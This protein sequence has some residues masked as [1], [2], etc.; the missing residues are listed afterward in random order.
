MISAEDSEAMSQ[1]FE[2]VFEGGVLRPVVPL[3]LAENERVRV[4]IS[5]LDDFRDDEFEDATD[6]IRRGFADLEAGRT[7]PLEQVDRDMR[8]RFGIPPRS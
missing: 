1:E 8:A 7:K 4:V 5:P 6:A 2:A 3:P